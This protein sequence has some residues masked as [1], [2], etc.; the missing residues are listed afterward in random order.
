MRKDVP[1]NVTRRKTPA[2][3]HGAPR[4]VLAST[5]GSMTAR[6]VT[7]TSA[8]VAAAASAA[9]LSSASLAAQKHHA[10]K[11]HSIANTIKVSYCMQ[12]QKLKDVL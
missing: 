5:V 2:A 1:K 11:K 12:M 6:F 10:H 7:A 9:N 8:A 3:P 4:T